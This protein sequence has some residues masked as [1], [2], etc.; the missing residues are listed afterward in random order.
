MLRLLYHVFGWGCNELQG[1]LM[2][3]VFTR[4]FSTKFPKNACNINEEYK[5]NIWFCVR[6]CFECNSKNCLL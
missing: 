3:K 4:K 6:N 5:D 1:S 2:F